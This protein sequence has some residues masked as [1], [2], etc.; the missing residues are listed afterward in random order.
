M[1]TATRLATLGALLGL[2]GCAPTVKVIRSSAQRPA[3]D[4]EVAVRFVETPPGATELARLDTVA[5][6][7]ELAPALEPLVVKTAELGG[8]LTKVDSVVNEIE[9]HTTTNNDGKTKHSV[10]LR[11]RIRGR[12][13]YV[14]R[15]GE[16]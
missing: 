5:S 16:Q 11:T 6:G 10:R 15:A 12:A 9:H 8:N 2:L 3:Y 7:Y 1:R 14:S 13:F 4:G